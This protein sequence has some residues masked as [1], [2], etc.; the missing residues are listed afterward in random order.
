MTNFN[1]G[2]S[3]LFW[4][5]LIQAIEDESLEEENRRI[6]IISPWIRDIPI[7]SS[8]LSADD[9]RSLIGVSSNYR[10]SML[11]DVLHAIKEIGFMV[12]IVTL[13]S[14]DKRLPKDSRYW[15]KKEAEFIDSLEEKGVNV[16]K[17]IG[18]HAKMYIF[19]H[20]CLTGSTN[21]TNQ[22]MFSNMENMTLTTNDN[23]ADFRSYII[24]ADAV[25]RG[26]VEYFE[27]STGTSPKR[28]ELDP[29]WNY[30]PD[31]NKD[32]EDINLKIPKDVDNRENYLHSPGMRLG[33]ISNNGSHHIEEHEIQ[34][35][36]LHIQSFEKELRNV[37]IELYKR[38][39]NM[40][41]AWVKQKKEGK[42]AKS[43]NKIWVHL[44]KIDRDKS[45][46][47]AA[48]D[49]IFTRK[50]PPYEAEDFEYGKIP[51]KENLD[52]QTIFTYGTNLSQL[53]TCLVGDNN[54]LFHDFDD[55]Y[56]VDQ[57]LRR[58]TATITRNKGMKEDDVKFFWRRLF[59]DNEAFSHIAFARNEL[60]HSKPLARH[61][62]IKCQDAL[63][64]FEKRLMRRF[65]D[66]IE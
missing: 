50:R 23:Y 32:L 29:N 28:L 62:A 11:S 44:L 48:V 35:L 65:A 1:Y 37:I 14:A 18:L 8:N 66:Y 39:S 33:G 22:G 15:L 30:E 58:F 61:R 3:E 6:L 13:D 42:I 5:L 25:L 21:C 20:G 38:E 54:N 59:G 56:L 27:K 19:P 51:D 2:H 16:W 52:P 64:I 17:K 36:N 34:S 45:L 4:E 60:F 43:P 10:I 40:M 53:K 41:A 9:F 57:S 12:D 7:S 24:N 47:D 55:T 31:T 26:S 49:Q 46:H 63:I